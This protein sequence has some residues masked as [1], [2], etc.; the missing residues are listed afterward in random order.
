MKRII[1][2][3]KLL[4]AAEKNKEQALQVLLERLKQAQQILKANGVKEFLAI[5]FAAEQQNLLDATLE[6]EKV[7]NEFNKVKSQILSECSVERKVQYGAR[8]WKDKFGNEHIIEY[9]IV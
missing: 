2:A 7:R 6:C 8:K 9:E 1:D 5:D 3:H 4:E